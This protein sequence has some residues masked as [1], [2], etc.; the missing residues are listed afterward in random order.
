MKRALNIITIILITSNLLS[1]QS[2]P[3][4][5]WKSI[6]TE[7]FELIFP[8]EIN[9]TAQIIANKLV[10]VYQF[11]GKSLNIKAKPISILLFNQSTISNGYAGI[12]PR[13]MGWYLTPLPS[14]SL[15]N[16]DWYNTLALHEYRHIHQFDKINTGMTR[17]G[18]ILFGDYGLSMLSY[19]IPNWWYE[20]DAIMIET[21]LS[22]SGRGRSPNFTMPIKANIINNENFSYNTAKFRS[23]KRYFPNHYYLGFL[24]VANARRHFGENIW[25]DII[26]K[27]SK[28]SICPYAFSRSLKKT[29]GF[30]SSQL[31]KRTIQELDSIWTD[32]IAKLETTTV[33]TINKRKKRYHWCNYDSPQFLNENNIVVRKSGLKT[34][35]TFYKINLDGKEKKLFRTSANSMSVNANKIVWTSLIPDVRWGERDYSDIYVYNE[36]TKKKIRL[37]HRQKYFSPSL[38]SDGTKIAAIEYSKDQKTTIVILDAKTGTVLKKIASPNNYFLRSPSW[39][40]DNKQLVFTKHH[41]DGQNICI[42]NIDNESFT[43][44]T[45]TSWEDIAKP[46]FYN[47]YILYNSS[48][49]GIGNLF[50]I[51]LTSKERFQVS[52]RNFGVS[53]AAISPDNSTLIFQD[54]DYKG[55]DISL[56]DLE[57]DKWKKI[58]NIQLSHDNFFSPILKQEQGGSIFDKKSEYDEFSINN[59]KKGRNGINIHSWGLYAAYP[60][61]Q[62]M[63]YSRNQLN[64]L[65]LSAGYEYNTTEN[66]N[67]GIFAVS[68]KGWFP[69][70]SLGL[71][72]SERKASY[73]HDNQQY[74]DQWNEHSAK[75]AMEVPLNLSRNAYNRSLSFATDIKYTYIQNKGELR[76]LSESGNGAFIPIHFSTTFRNFLHSASSNINPDFGQYVGISYRKTISDESISG[77]LVSFYSNLYFPGLFKTHSLIISGAYEI[78]RKYEEENSTLYYFS[79]EVPRIKGYESN[80]S[81]LFYSF[82]A[83]YKLPLWNPDFGLGG[84]VYFKRLKANLFYHQGFSKLHTYE[85]NMQS[86]GIELSMEFFG[87]R[88]ER[89][90]ELGVRFSYLIPEQEFKSN[91]LIFSLPF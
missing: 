23:Y 82:L 28:F 80:T 56:I 88:L 45:K 27:T 58:N 52:S 6:E 86:T 47:N 57:P 71:I 50:A 31:Y 85:R 77:N 76:Y 30:T 43:E 49:S 63:L 15:G 17:I 29:I 14:L 69:I 72:S 60:N 67:T 37:T 90:I 62:A 73:V 51:D 25:G 61:L 83:E 39:S 12:A 19:S 26:K 8:D 89:P 53:N 2:P 91:F 13:R 70:V 59:Y 84:L 75:L 79:S 54:Y 35:S 21:S 74:N 3:E 46:V 10:K 55:F 66:T 42:L 48:Y 16:E 81:E 24:M 34:S 78:Q 7:N 32:Q 44:I 41:R 87:L 1:Q 18:S 9:K 5:K 11:E 68:Y 33:S 4:L 65:Q 36:N 40:A 64:T 38:S 20:G 22:N